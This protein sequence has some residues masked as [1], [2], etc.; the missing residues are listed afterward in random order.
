MAFHMITGQFPSKAAIIASHTKMRV[1]REV[2]YTRMLR[3]PHIIKLWVPLLSALL[4]AI[5]SLHFFQL[6]TK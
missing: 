1:Q 2:D 3:H 5:I 4:T 6:A